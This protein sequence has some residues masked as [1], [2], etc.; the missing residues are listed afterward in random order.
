LRNITE[1]RDALEQLFGYRIDGFAYPYGDQNSEV[2]QL[3][4]SAG[5]L[6]ARG[7]D[8]TRSVFPPEDPMNFKPSCHFLAENFWQEFEYAQAKGNV[9]YFWGHS[10]ELLTEADW[11]AFEEKIERL[12]EKGEW[13]SL[14]S[15]FQHQ[16]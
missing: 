9:F 11:L 10:Y 1:G 14:P 4:K 15:L 3:V 12:S 8:G 5:H 16:A 7:T 13:I 2:R 6:Y